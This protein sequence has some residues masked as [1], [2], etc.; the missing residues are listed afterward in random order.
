MMEVLTALNVLDPILREG[1]TTKLGISRKF[2][3]SQPVISWGY[4]VMAPEY[5]S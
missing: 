5:K 4:V 2:A 1:M 3:S